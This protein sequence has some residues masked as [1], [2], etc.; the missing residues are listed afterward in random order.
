MMGMRS[1]GRVPIFF[2][3]NQK[4]KK[5]IYG[6][7]AAI[8]TIGLVA[9]NKENDPEQANNDGEFNF[10]TLEAGENAISVKIT[11]CDANKTFF[12]LY[13]SKAQYDAMLD[14]LGS[15]AA[16]IA[17]DVEYL[18]ETLTVF[19]DLGYNY[20]LSNFLSVG[21]DTLTLKNLEPE[22]EYVVWA[23]YLDTL[24]NN[25]GRLYDYT[26]KTT[27]IQQNTAEF[28]IVSE[29]DTLF[30]L[31]VS[32]TTQGWVSMTELKSTVESAG[33]A[34]AYL[35][36]ILENAKEYDLLDYVI[37][38]G[39]YNFTLAELSLNSAGTYLMMVAPVSASGVI[40]GE[41]VT[42][43][44]DYAGSGDTEN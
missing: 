17:D 2:Q 25:D 31:T 5:I 10:E 38:H 18:K 27:S 37:Y 41:I 44:F 20:T 42:Y 22:T 4:M 14:S 39:N 32:D 1:L 3:K 13:A 40:N 21:S 43:E 26:V 30:R 7:A 15:K 9:C 24:Y 8:L 35:E 29:A 36:P 11:P 16:V 34:K 6:F 12:S 23:Y 19:R 33:G 28:K